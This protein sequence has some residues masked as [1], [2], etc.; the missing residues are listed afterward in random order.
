MLVLEIQPETEVYPKEFIVTATIY[1]VDTVCTTASGYVID[2]TTHENI[3]IIAISRDLQSHFE[4]GDKV[5]VSGVDGYNGIYTVS[6]LMHKRW[7]NRIDFLVSS[8]ASLNKFYNVIIEKL[9]NE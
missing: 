6:D 9:E 3:K 4:F 5:R 1:S 8:E 7:T 2:S